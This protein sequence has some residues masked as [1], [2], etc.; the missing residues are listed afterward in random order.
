MQI[1]VS[2]ANDMEQLDFIEDGGLASS[3]VRLHSH[4]NWS[5][6]NLSNESFSHSQARWFS[7]LPD[8]KY[9][10]L[11]MNATRLARK[12]ALAQG[13]NDRSLRR[14]MPDVA[15]LL[16]N[17]AEWQPDPSL[18]S[19]EYAAHTAHVN[20]VWRQGLLCYIYADICALPSSEARIQNCIRQASEALQE[21]SWIQSITWPMFM[22]GVH[23]ILPAHRKVLE[24]SYIAMSTTLSFATPRSIVGFLHKVWAE[25]DSKEARDSSWR[26]VMMETGMQLNVFL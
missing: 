11:F 14:L 25:M 22:L 20:E 1:D 26:G 3:A 15:E 7:N 6:D 10:C 2:L 18:V 17:I 19:A 23:A 16:Q 21:L 24:D 12:V 4:A 8:Y 13:A 9:F 5:P